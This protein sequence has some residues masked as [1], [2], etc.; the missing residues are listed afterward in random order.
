MGPQVLSGLQ[1]YY[2][3]HQAQ[4]AATTWAL[5]LPF[6]PVQAREDMAQVCQCTTR[7]CLS[8]ALLLGR[9]FTTPAQHSLLAHCSSVCLVLQCS[10]STEV[11]PVSH[12][13]QPYAALHT[14][15]T[16]QRHLWGRRLPWPL[17][18]ELLVR[19]SAALSQGVLSSL[20]CSC[21][22]VLAQT[23]VEAC[24]QAMLMYGQTLRC[25]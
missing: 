21:L 14:H 4:D 2:P 6:Q 9:S 17:C 8:I 24:S 19:A 3:D 20:T 7:T 22:I 13:S 15:S 5:A 12:T 18:T 25:G 10:P 11:I 16:C 23:A 1:N